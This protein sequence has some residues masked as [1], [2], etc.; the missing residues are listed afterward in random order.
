MPIAP[1]PQLKAGL[2]ARGSGSLKGP[3][4]TPTGAPP[5]KPPKGL[6]IEHRV[7][8]QAPAEVI[9]EVLSDLKS[10]GEWCKLYPKAAGEIHIGS[11]LDLTLALPGRPQEE[12]H[13]TVLEWVPNE[14]LHWRLTMLGGLVKTTRYFEIETLAEASCIV[15][16]GELIAGLMGPS[17]GKRMG[18]TIYRAFVEMND[19]LKARAELLW[20]RRKP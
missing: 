12:I 11:T 18:R 7:G 10:W 2:F 5:P 4:A 1:S 3:K 8:V 15:S 14:Q 16:N 13:P 20:Q 9:W 19:E 17:V 6:R